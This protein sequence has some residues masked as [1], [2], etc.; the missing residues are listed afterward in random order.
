[1]QVTKIECANH[2]IKCYRNRLE[3]IL[4]DYPQYKGKG[5]LTQNAIRR[6]TVGARCAIKMHTTDKDINLLRKDLRNGPNHVFNDHRNC[7]PT[8]C[9]IAAETTPPAQ[10]PAPV[11]I[12]ATQD[13]QDIVATLEEIIDQDLEEQ[14]ELYREEDEARGGDSD[15]KRCNIQ[16]D[17]FFKIQR[18]GDR[19]VSI[20]PKLITNSTSNIAESFMN[21]RCKFDGGKY[22]NRIQRGSFL[23]RTCGAGLRFQLGPDWTNEVWPQATGTQPGQI[24]L[25][26]GRAQVHNHELDTKRKS[27]TEYRQQRKKSK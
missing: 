17:L 22:F 7:S 21:I 4:Q 5:G 9:K 27:T 24:S 20:A 8:F 19:L 14:Y 23:H 11:N 26:F 3:A 6:L 18:A 15:S 25:T 1:M 2:A 16:D 10:P 12:S 13:T